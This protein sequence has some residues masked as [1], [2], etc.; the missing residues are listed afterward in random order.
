MKYTNVKLT[1]ANSC[2]TEILCRQ[3]VIR[4]IRC[5][6][7]SYGERC[8]WHLSHV[9]IKT[10]SF[11]EALLTMVYFDVSS[12]FILLFSFLL[13]IFCSIDDIAIYYDNA[14][15]FLV[16]INKKLHKICSFRKNTI[17]RFGFTKLKLTKNKS[18]LECNIVECSP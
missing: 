5:D 17:F 2:L 11:C 13:E 1:N 10:V 12:Y 7:R 3:K 9:M 6:W 4:V 8:E 16:N 14:R 18:F 15:F